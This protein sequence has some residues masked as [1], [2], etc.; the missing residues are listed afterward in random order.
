VV[1]HVPKGANALPVSIPEKTMR[2]D[3]ADLVIVETSPPM[4][5]RNARR[6]VGCKDMFCHHRIG[7]YTQTIIIYTTLL[8]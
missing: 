7:L 6:S 5:N 2:V 8:L 4:R 1:A 3:A